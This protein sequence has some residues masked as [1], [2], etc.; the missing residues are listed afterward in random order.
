[1]FPSFDDPVAAI[2][3]LQRALESRRQSDWMGASTAGA[4]SYPPINIFQQLTHYANP[5]LEKALASAPVTVTADPKECS[6]QFN[7]VGVAKFT[8]SCDIAKSALVARSVNYQNEAAPAG[9]QASIKVGDQA[10]WDR[11]E[12]EHEEPLRQRKG[13]QLRPLVGGPDGVLG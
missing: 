3:A 2:T 9:T 12:R 7:P 4:G 6:F 11:A 13:L 8:T 5:Q 1:M 10:L